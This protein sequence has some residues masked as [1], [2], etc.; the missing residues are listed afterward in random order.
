[1]HILI[2]KNYTTFSEKYVHQQLTFEMALQW[3]YAFV[4]YLDYTECTGLKT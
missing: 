4:N 3:M 2:D 1:M